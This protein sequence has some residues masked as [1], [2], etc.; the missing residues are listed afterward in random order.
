MSALE[1]SGERLGIA[2]IPIC[3]LGLIE[4]VPQD[5]SPDVRLEEFVRFD[6]PRRKSHVRE[7]LESITFT[8]L[9][10]VIFTGFVAQATQVP[11][12]SMKPTILVGDHFFIDKIVFP[13]NFPDSLRAYLPTRNIRRG[14]IIVDRKSTR[15]NSS[16]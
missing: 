11:T 8:L 2:E 10:I 6:T 15:L 9:F 14:D 13:G 3:S 5:V 1:P 16:H 7:W 12:E 4:R